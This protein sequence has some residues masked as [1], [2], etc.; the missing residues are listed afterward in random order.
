MPTTT[1]SMSASDEVSLADIMRKL[2]ENKNWM[3]EKFKKLSST[4]DS[5]CFRVKTLEDEQKEHIK[6]LEFYGAEIEDLKA[7]LAAASQDY[8]NFK[9]TQ[10]MSHISKSIKKI[11]SENMLK[12]LVLSGIPESK[13]EDLPS[14][15]EKMCETLNT[16]F[17]KSDIDAV[18]RVKKQK[19]SSSSDPQI[20]NIRFNSMI[21]RDNFYDS[22]KYM[23]KNNFNSTD[24]GFDKEN[25]I[26][27][28]EK[29]SKATQELFYYARMKKKELNYK[30]AW[31]YHGNIF[32]REQKSTEAIR[33]ASK[34]DLTKL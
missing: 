33:I 15:I 31:T 2:D 32:L 20:V 13:K 3:E 12:T 18:Y 17:T 9:T 22:R 30:Y 10:D 27:I 23:A 34:E 19:D 8:S 1:R 11:E 5:L 24:L 21:A 7:K 25:K 14:V 29:L 26:Y 6:T 4:I 16:T 28:N